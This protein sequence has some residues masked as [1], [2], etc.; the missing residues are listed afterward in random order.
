MILLNNV[1]TAVKITSYSK[2][3]YQNVLFKFIY[4]VCRV[5]M[6]IHIHRAKSQCEPCPSFKK[7]MNENFL[8]SKIHKLQNQ[9]QT[10]THCPPKI[11]SN[12][13]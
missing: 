11:E 6:K 13:N 9:I 8:T 1:Q 2:N 12:I 4:F 5:Y 7:K 3:L 10:T